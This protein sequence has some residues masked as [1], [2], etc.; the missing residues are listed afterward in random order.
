MKLP[1][2]LIVGRSR[3]LLEGLRCLLEPMCTVHLELGG[4]REIGAAVAS[5]DPEVALVDIGSAASGAGTA[6]MLAEAN[7]AISL[8]CLTD[9]ADEPVGTFRSLVKSECG[10]AALLEA[11]FARY[12]AINIAE[13]R[14]TAQP[15]PDFL[16]LQEIQI[17]R[18]VIRGLTISQI[19][20]I[21]G[22]SRRTAAYYKYSFMNR[23][24]LHSL[25][26]LISYAR[27]NI[28]DLL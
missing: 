2:V 27:E 6:R 22:I 16:K 19:S 15:E 8:V 12:K 5:F 13:L 20:T 9:G 25:E 11:V 1:R 18:L 4:E 24:N 17:L 14:Y 3:L 26:A 7:P 21:L 23:R 10:S 28:P